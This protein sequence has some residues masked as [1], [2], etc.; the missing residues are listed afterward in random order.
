MHTIE[1]YSQVLKET[2][3]V[4]DLG[5]IK[6]G[7]NA[8]N[9]NK[10]DESYLT[11]L[12]G[13]TNS[14]LKDVFDEVSIDKELMQAELEKYV[15]K[16][17]KLESINMIFA[18][19]SEG[20]ETFVDEVYIINGNRY[21]SAKMIKTFFPIVCI[22]LATVYSST[23][24]KKGLFRRRINIQINQEEKPEMRFALFGKNK[25]FLESLE[26]YQNAHLEKE[27]QTEQHS[28]K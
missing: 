27:K 20:E 25:E 12:I 22:E 17:F 10:M 21:L 8:E 11:K 14:F 13:D 7:V 2:K 26:L 1:S 16:E 19:N 4:N 15:R 5:S 3:G 9:L 18:P 23:P 24:Q 6:Y 28:L